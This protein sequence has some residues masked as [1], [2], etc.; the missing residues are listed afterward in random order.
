MTDEAVLGDTE[1]AL[2][3]SLS[4]HGAERSGGGIM[5]QTVLPWRL[6]SILMCSHVSCGGALSNGATGRGSSFCRP[7]YNRRRLRALG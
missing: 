2:G 1:R 3:C 6:W 7:F 5:T 4:I